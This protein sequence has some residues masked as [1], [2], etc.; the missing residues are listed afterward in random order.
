[1][2]QFTKYLFMAIALIFFGINQVYS[3]DVALNRSLITATYLGKADQVQA[4]LEDGAN[5]RAKNIA[6][7]TPLIIA[8]GN[9]DVS[10]VSMLISQDPG[11]INDTDNNDHTALWHAKAALDDRLNF[12]YMPKLEERK[13]E[14]ALIIDALS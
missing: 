7:E 14:Y 10:I 4:L 2:I 6:G 12:Q 8:A 3:G 9:G 11:V 1:M 5:P 13:N